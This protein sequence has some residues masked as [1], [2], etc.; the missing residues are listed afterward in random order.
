MNFVDGKQLNIST[1]L[2]SS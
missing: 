2:E 1:H